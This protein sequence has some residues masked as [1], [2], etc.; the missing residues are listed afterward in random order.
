[1]KN[2]GT[3][4]KIYECS[5]RRGAIEVSCFTMIICDL[6]IFRL[7]HTNRKLCVD[8]DVNIWMCKLRLETEDNHLYDRAKVLD[9]R[10]FHFLKSLMC[11][12]LMF[13]C[14]VSRG[15]CRSPPF[16]TCS[17][18]KLNSHWS[19]FVVRLRSSR[20]SKHQ[21]FWS[22]KPKHPNYILKLFELVYLIRFG[23]FQLL[24]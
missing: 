6:R 2:I 13:V 5:I 12:V 19:V 11:A 23:Q 24:S 9:T 22:P 4:K 15:R 20:Q 10:I 7:S 14:V 21:I 16:S 18:L 3:Y 1:M 8:L 17:N